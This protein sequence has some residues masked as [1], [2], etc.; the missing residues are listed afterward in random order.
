MCV[1]QFII[2]P[3]RKAV[4]VC[5]C[6]Y[7][8]PSLLSLVGVFGRSRPEKIIRWHTHTHTSVKLVPVGVQPVLHLLNDSLGLLSPNDN[9][10]IIILSF[11]SFS[12]S[13]FRLIWLAPIRGPP[14]SGGAGNDCGNDWKAIKVMN[15]NDQ[16]VLHL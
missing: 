6:F 9:V 3:K 16:C 13:S 14:P 8:F 4:C 7:F 10:F 15:P 12:S 11:R 2:V 1:S 5:V